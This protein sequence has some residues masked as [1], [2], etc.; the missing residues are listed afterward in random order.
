MHSA[1][2]GS[3]R[4]GTAYAVCLLLLRKQ[5]ATVIP[6]GRADNNHGGNT[7]LNSLRVIYGYNISVSHPRLQAIC[8][9]NLC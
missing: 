2:P 3:S 4:G 8:E 5:T 6:P 1:S 9:L 7:A